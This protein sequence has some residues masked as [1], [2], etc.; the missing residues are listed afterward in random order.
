MTIREYMALKTAMHGGSY[1]KRVVLKAVR[2][3]KLLA[4]DQTVRLGDT[5]DAASLRFTA[6]SL[7]QLA[8]EVLQPIIDGT[9]LRGFDLAD[10]AKRVRCPV[11]ILQADPACGSRCNPCVFLIVTREHLDRAFADRICVF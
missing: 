1:N 7:S 10:I 6:R 5:R 11:L 2:E 3:Y 9:W 4:E 8:P